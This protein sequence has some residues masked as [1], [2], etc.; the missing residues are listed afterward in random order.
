M[1]FLDETGKRWQRIKLG[2]G[3]LGSTMLVPI[4]V[5]IAASL[6][7]LPSWGNV[8]LPESVSN[9]ATQSSSRQDV[10][11]AQTLIHTGPAAGRAASTTNSDSPTLTSDSTIQTSSAPT[12]GGTSTSSSAATTS[13]T[14]NS[15]YGRGHQPTRS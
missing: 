11:S 1:I 14:G 6:L 3:M 7:Y 5:L 8:P 2:T 10:Q 15:A 9:S 4:I 13:P 12:T